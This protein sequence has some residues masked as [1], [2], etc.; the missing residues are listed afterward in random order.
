VNLADFKKRTNSFQLGGA[1]G[2]ESLAG[3]L[4]DQLG[5]DAS[6]GDLA[7][8]V[9]PILSDEKAFGDP[10]KLKRRLVNAVT[11][12]LGV[13]DPMNS[14]L[15]A[16]S[17]SNF[18]ESGFQQLDLTAFLRKLAEVGF[19][20]NIEAMKELFGKRFTAPMGALIHSML[21]DGAFDYKMDMF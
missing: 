13:D 9:L 14:K 21:D 18:V 7:S 17:V 6:G 11:Q 4:A 15:V 10:N 3:L 1:K 16:E 8:A 12:A 2:A 5:I 19:D 20:K